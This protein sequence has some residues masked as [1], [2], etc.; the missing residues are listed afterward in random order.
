MSLLAKAELLVEKGSFQSKAETEILFV[1]SNLD[2]AVNFAVQISKILGLAVMEY[3]LDFQ[4][5]NVRRE[6]LT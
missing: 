4:R 1:S 2:S 6:E 3:Q 5:T